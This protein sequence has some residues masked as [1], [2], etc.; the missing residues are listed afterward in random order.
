[1]SVDDYGIEV[2]KKAA[3]PQTTGSK[4][5][6][7]L[8]T[9]P[10]GGTGINQNA[11]FIEVEQTSATVETFRYYESSGKATL[12]NTIVVTYTDS[13]KTILQSVEWS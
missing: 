7:I 4:S 6:Y 10:G 3:V 9:L 2:L 1:M 11:K 5:E 8:R 13:T 12:Y